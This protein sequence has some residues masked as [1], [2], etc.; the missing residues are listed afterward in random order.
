MLIVPEID[1]E[2]LHCLTAAFVGQ[3]EGYSYFENLFSNR[4]LN[5]S[6]VKLQSEFLHYSLFAMN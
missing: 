5:V 2:A 1:I 3:I 6:T 4:H